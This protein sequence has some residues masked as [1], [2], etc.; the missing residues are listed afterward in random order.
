[1]VLFKD[2]IVGAFKRLDFHQDD[3]RLLA[4]LMTDALVA[5]HIGGMFGTGD[6]PFIFEVITRVLR[7]VVGARIRG[8]LKIYVDDPIAITVKSDLEHD[9]EALKTV[10]RGLLGAEAVDETGRKAREGRQLEAIGWSL[11]LDTQEVGLA[12][13]NMHK[14]VYGFF[15][16]VETGSV[17]RRIVEKLAAYAARYAAVLRHAKPLTTILYQEF[18]RQPNR[19]GSIPGLSPQGCQAIQMWR[20]IL[21]MQNIARGESFRAKMTSFRTRERQVL[22]QFDASLTGAG[23]GLLQVQPAPGPPIVLGYR[24]AMFPFSLGRDSSYQNFAEFLAV[25]LGEIELAMRGGR[26]MCLGLCGDSATVLRWGS[27]QERARGGARE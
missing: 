4:A 14:A 18:L 24:K 23:L 10:L 17:P 13:K 11:D 3:V 8:R 15:S 5:L 26:Q 27:I 1:L 6:F 20:I 22:L 2:D 9:K 19:R 21:V 12:T 16:I 7:R 25:V